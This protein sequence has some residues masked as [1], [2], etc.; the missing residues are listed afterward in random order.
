MTVV[1]AFRKLT[2]ALHILYDRREAENIADMVIEKLTG[3]RR[4]ERALK[5]E[6]E[7]TAHQE[8]ELEHYSTELL[9]HKPVQYV[10]Q[11]AWFYRLSF[12][13][14]EHVLIPRPET[15]ELVQWIITDAKSISHPPSSIL[16]IGTGSGCIPV[17]L[18]KQ[19][20]T[21]VVTAIDINAQALHV[22]KKNADI[23]NTSIDFLLVDVL[24][25]TQLNTLPVFD[26]IVSNPPYIPATDMTGMRENVLNYEPHTALFVPNDD[27]LLFYKAIAK[28]AKL[29]L[30]AGGKVYVEI[31]EAQGAAV[32]K[33]FEINGFLNCIIKKDMQGKDRMVKATIGIRE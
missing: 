20:D 5:K 19:L 29:H 11:E 18:K 17:A 22:A 8:K 28:F 26:I 3:L 13:V 2:G 24:N 14:N 21:P 12:F 30:H 23:N 27:P 32:K 7:L 33:L 6:L 1:E 15:E 9:Q 10:L 4:M 16:D 25:E 31:H